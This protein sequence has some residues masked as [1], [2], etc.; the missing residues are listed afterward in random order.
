MVMDILKKVA[1]TLVAVP[2]KLEEIRHCDAEYLN[3]DRSVQIDGHSCGAQ[4]AFTIGARSY[5]RIEAVG[6][7]ETLE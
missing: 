1:D 7:L 3:I 4:R 5:T 6:E 2:K